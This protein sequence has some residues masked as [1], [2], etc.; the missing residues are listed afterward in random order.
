MT[1][2]WKV[3][4]LVAI[5]L[6]IAAGAL[7]LFAPVS[8]FKAP[9]EAEVA[10]ATGRNFHI[11][12]PVSLTFT[13]ELALDLGAITLGAG[14]GD[15]ATPLV[16]AR[17]AVVAV[18]F[19]P[20]LS[21]KSEA[22]SLTL[23]GAEIVVGPGDEGWRFAGPDGAALSTPFDA[24]AFGDVRLIDSRINVGGVVIGA[25]DVRL[26]WPAKGQA[27]SI[28]GVVGFREKSFTIDAVIERRDALMAGGRVPMRVEFNSELAHGSIDGVADL[29]RSAFEGGI[30]IS[31]PSTRALAAF[32]GA[33]IPGDRAFGEL[34]LSAALRAE[35]EAINLRDAKFALGEMTGAGTLAIR[36]SGDTPAFSGDL[37]V[38]RLDLSTF[39]SFTPHEGV[40]GW[41][42]TAFDLS[43]IA[44][45]EADLSLKARSAGIAGLS[46][47]NLSV[48]MSA[49]SGR[50]WARIDSALAY[51]SILHGTV[52]VEL[53]GATPR[54]GFTLAAEGVDAQSALAAAFD[55]SGL[56]GRA[57]IKLDLTA[58]GAN[59]RALIASLAGSADIVL[60]DGALEGLDPAQL[61]RTAADEGGP[62]G[63]EPGASTAFKRLSG[64]FDIQNGRAWSSSIRLV[65]NMVRM[66]ADGVFDLPARTLALR[67]FP[68]FVAG[69]DG[70]RDPANEGH[71][72]MPFALSGAWGAVVAEPD[73]DALMAAL[74]SGRVTLEGIELLPEP[75][76][77]WFKDLIASGA[78]PPWPVGIER[79]GP[80]V[81]WQPW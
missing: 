52:T 33:A 19:L 56:T 22:S 8:G 40:T 37:A 12:G 48:T 36:L 64:A 27:L 74:K 57:N 53:D 24:L 62:Q 28:S 79:P 9:L 18:R 44:G 49:R 31:A 72:A 61:A 1:R 32:L 73:W 59:R 41:N 63:A 77:S 13:P 75:R 16:S 20:L 78:P 47:Q 23:E 35:P 34:S 42:D 68:V 6:L 76:R 60:I 70:S 43:G 51:A 25:Q 46:I 50:L 69:D 11:E 67:A 66:D 5:A 21:G 26:R 3:L 71:L 58:S 29:A 10:A 54:F 39:L 45:F 38:D 4:G 81:N 30:S 65:S 55:G 80:A 2:L 17:R 14:R 15:D 7:V